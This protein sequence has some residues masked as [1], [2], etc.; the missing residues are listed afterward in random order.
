MRT[1]KHE[2]ED[3][4]SKVTKMCNR[5][6]AHDISNPF[7]GHTSCP[8]SDCR[9]VKCGDYE[10]KIR[11]KKESVQKM[12][13]MKTGSADPVL[14]VTSDGPSNGHKTPASSR[15]GVSIAELKRAFTKKHKSAQ[16]S[17]QRLRGR[18]PKSSLQ[19]VPKKSVVT[20]NANDNNPPQLLPELPLPDPPLLDP[21][22]PEMVDNN[23]RTTEATEPV[24]S[25][26]SAA[27]CGQY[28]KACEQLSIELAMTTLTPEQ[29][30]ACLKYTAIR[31]C[32]GDI[33]MAVKKIAIANQEM[34][35][36]TA[37]NIQNPIQSN[38]VVGGGG[39]TTGRSNGHV[40]NTS[41]TSVRRLCSTVNGNFKPNDAVNYSPSFT[42]IRNNH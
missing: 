29:I 39:D 21:P 38:G 11:R 5:C 3:T 2:S 22:S 26:S 17:G 27:L 28:L 24:V 7:K 36:G 10:E 19:M 13:A 4:A 35:F 8:F 42:P 23:S 20:D 14:S 31:D 34:S 40:A 16:L 25:G 9:C 41:A 33:G 1:R 37:F 15:K 12:R 6:K 18:R 32:L 30:I